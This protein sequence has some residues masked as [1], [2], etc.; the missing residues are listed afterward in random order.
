MAVV[1]ME[2]GASLFLQLIRLRQF[3]R[4]TQMIAECQRTADGRVRLD[5]AM[6]LEPP[7][8]GAGIVE[9]ATSPP[10]HAMRLDDA[11]LG[12]DRIQ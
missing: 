3:G 2:R 5:D 8:S 10:L 4:A 12:I 9:R 1:G 7:L 6:K 11:P